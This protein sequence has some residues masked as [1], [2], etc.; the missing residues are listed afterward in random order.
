MQNRGHR[1]FV[2]R[3]SGIEIPSA[4]TRLVPHRPDEARVKFSQISF[5]QLQRDNEGTD[6]RSRDCQPRLR[7]RHPCRD[8]N[9]REVTTPPPYIQDDRATGRRVVD[10]FENGHESALARWQPGPLRHGPSKWTSFGASSLDQLGLFCFLNTHR[11]SGSTL[12]SLLFFSLLTCLPPSVRPPLFAHVFTALSLLLSSSVGP[13]DDRGQRG[14]T[15][16]FP[17]GSQ[18]VILTAALKHTYYYYYI[19]S[20]H[21][22]IMFSLYIY[23]YTC[24]HTIYY[25][26]FAYI[27][28]CTNTLPHARTHTYCYMCTRI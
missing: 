28:I 3:G 2:I 5:H 17:A 21:A 18:V 12:P 14:N 1:P 6:H 25:Y 19:T 11:C 10:A 13:E 23:I 16:P 20:S 15:R 26:S 27:Y 7:H 24:I 9:S 8:Q 22:H 4:S